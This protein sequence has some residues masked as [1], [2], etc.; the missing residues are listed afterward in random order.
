LNEQPELKNGL[1]PAFNERLKKL[2]PEDRLREVL[3]SFSIVK[4]VAFRIQKPGISQQDVEKEL[5][6]LEPAPVSWCPQAFTLEREKIR[7]LQETPLYQSHALYIQSLSSMAAVLALDPRPGERVLDLTAAPGSKTT[8]IALLMKGEGELVAN[9]K[10]RHRFFKLKAIAD[11]QGLPNIR[12][13]MIPGEV[14]GFREPESFDKVLLDAPCSSEGKFKADDPKSF[15]YWKPSKVREMS[16]LQ[17][18]LLLSALSAVKPGGRLL[19]STCTFAPE[20]NEEV[21]TWGLKRFGS[22]VEIE[23]VTCAFPDRLMKVVPEWEGKIYDPA[24]GNAMR[25]LP[26]A[27]M[28]AFFICS[29]LKRDSWTSRKERE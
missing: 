23:R 13:T 3:D 7:S 28:S 18:R 14:W 19:Y 17:K 1:P 10:N 24:L 27:T 21:L 20:E 11:A 16:K 25:I 4:K 5:A 6:A 26:D 15:G 12:L 29:I 2:I 8:Q 9:E 22:C